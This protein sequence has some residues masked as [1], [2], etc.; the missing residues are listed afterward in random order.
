MFCIYIFFS[1]VSGIT[2]VWIIICY[3]QLALGWIRF[4]Q[5]TWVT[6][7][8]IMHHHIIRMELPEDFHQW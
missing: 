1:S 6:L 3:F 5:R 8:R 7:C 4:H 2:T